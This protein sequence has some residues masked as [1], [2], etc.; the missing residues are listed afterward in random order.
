MTT[1]FC[2]LN[3]GYQEDIFRYS[4]YDRGLT[5]Y[6]G[7]IYTTRVKLGMTLIH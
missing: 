6:S 1:Y 7:V 5:Y 3:F 4:E 2:D